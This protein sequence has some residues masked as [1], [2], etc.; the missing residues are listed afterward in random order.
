MG[1]RTYSR[2]AADGTRKPTA[3]GIRTGKFI[4]ETRAELGGGGEI[5]E[6]LAGLE[7]TQKL[8]AWLG[9]N[10]TDFS[11]ETREEAGLRNVSEAEIWQSFLDEVNEAIDVDDTTRLAELAQVNIDQ[12]GDDN[13]RNFS[14]TEAGN[15]MRRL[16]PVLASM[17]PAL[18][19]EG[20]VPQGWE[21]RDGDV[22]IVRNIN[23]TTFGIT[24]DNYERPG[25]RVTWSLDIN[26]E[27]GDGFNMPIITGNRPGDISWQDAIE[28]ARPAI[29]GISRFTRE[30]NGFTFGDIEVLNVNGRGLMNIL[31]DRFDLSPRNVA[32]AM[33]A[34][35]NAR[36]AQLQPIDDLG[37]GPNV[38]FVQGRNGS[39]AI[40][41][42]D[43]ERSRTYGDNTTIEVTNR[44]GGRT[45]ATWANLDT[46]LNR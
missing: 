20:I 17:V 6:G 13:G 9:N 18:G 12:Y 7:P 37:E 42:S 46:I 44:G 14:Q 8:S 21:G 43:D 35:G 10:P 16:Q 11:T 32:G 26:D 29:N 27:D 19:G 36:S 38:F 33:A 2:R 24:P 30:A 5:D 25:R 28:L 34:I 15:A 3:L 22:G 45:L 39:T 40:I 31:N 23:G 1:T 4:A 41:G